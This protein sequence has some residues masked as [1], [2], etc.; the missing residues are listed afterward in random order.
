VTT[1]DDLDAWL[2]AR[3]NE[4][5]AWTTMQVIGEVAWAH[6]SLDASGGRTPN[7]E[8][9]A[10]TLNR[11]SD[12]EQLSVRLARATMFAWAYCEHPHAVLSNDK[13]RML[14]ERAGY[15]DGNDGADRLAVRCCCTEG[16][17]TAAAEAGRGV[18][19]FVWHPSS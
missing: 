3:A 19:I 15:V 11:L 9:L 17:V 1:D 6:A 14:F 12:N 13:W 18:E 2:G 5:P 10:R 7:G 4:V 8:R 16:M